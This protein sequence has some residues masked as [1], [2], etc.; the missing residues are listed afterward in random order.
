MFRKAVILAAATGLSV[1]ALAALAGW[2][3]SSSVAETDSRGSE[4]PVDIYVSA[5]TGND[6]GQCLSPDDACRSI[7]GAIDKIPMTIESK[8]TVH[9]ALGTYPGGIVLADRLSPNRSV[10]HLRG[11]PRA[12]ISGDG[13]QQ[14]G[15]SIFKVSGIVLENLD[16][17]GFT[18]SGVVVHYTCPFDLVK[19]TITANGGH[20]IDA[21]LSSGSIVQSVISDNAKNGITWD[22]GTLT[23]A[24]APYSPSPVPRGPRK[25]DADIN[26][27]PFDQSIPGS[28]ARMALRNGGVIIE[29]NAGI[30][31]LAVASDVSFH[32][33]ARVKDNAVGLSALHGGRIDLMLRADVTVQSNRSYQLLADCHGDVE[34]YGRAPVAVTCEELEYGVC[35]PW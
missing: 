21:K 15:L 19:S 10:I 11:E 7:Q 24:D 14:T 33:W 5:D 13:V 20:G 34:H 26:P 27:V 6:M 17:T 16:V 18:G 4:A 32:G 22:V 3:G 31:L 2:S 23:L 28:A 8:V 12:A 1:L 35:R 25:L 9:I 29:R 30:G